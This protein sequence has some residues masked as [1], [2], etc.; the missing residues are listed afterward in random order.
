MSLIWK[1]ITLVLKRVQKLKKSN[2][3]NEVSTSL[4]FEP[5]F[6]RSSKFEVTSYNNESS[7]FFYFIDW[8][9]FIVFARDFFFIE[10]I[11]IIRKLIF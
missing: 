2:L 9:S 8:F 4:I 11:K 7:K 6:V 10:Q 1:G 5:N 3:K